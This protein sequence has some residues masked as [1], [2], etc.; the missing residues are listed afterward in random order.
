[1]RGSETVPGS[2]PTSLSTVMPAA[3][4]LEQQQ[5]RDR[6]TRAHEGFELEL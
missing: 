5:Q 6:S 3:L 1:M 2:R 4:A